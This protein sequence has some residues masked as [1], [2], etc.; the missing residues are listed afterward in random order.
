M[1]QAGSQQGAEEVAALVLADI[2]SWREIMRTSAIAGRLAQCEF[3]PPPW[4]LASARA[5]GGLA[6]AVAC[7]L[8]GLAC[9]SRTELTVDGPNGLDAGS[10]GADAMLADVVEA[11][12]ADT[13][14]A[15]T[16]PTPSLL[17]AQLDTSVDASDTSVDASQDVPMV[18]DT[19]PP[20]GNGDATDPVDATAS[21]DA[22]CGINASVDASLGSSGCRRVATKLIL[23]YPPPMDG[24]APVDAA[25]TI[26]MDCSFNA[27]LIQLTCSAQ[28]ASSTDAGEVDG[29]GDGV[30][31]DSASKT[32]AYSSVAEFV[33]EASLVGNSRNVGFTYTTGELL[34]WIPD[35]PLSRSNVFDSC[36]KIISSGGVAVTEWDPHGRPTAMAPRHICRTDN[37]EHYAYDD[38][39]KTV[40]HMIIT[41]TLTPAPAGV[42]DCIRLVQ[43]FVFDDDGNV[44][45]ATQR[46][47]GTPS[48]IFPRYEVQEST[49]VCI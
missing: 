30:S 28:A 9:A 18:A 11:A 25:P 3:R 4:P 48:G 34:D 33:A 14:E 16:I 24:G 10:Q 6:A 29:G 41:R 5:P 12:P 40:T 44:L 23:V 7:A 8:A 49:L 17:D 39:L 1:G 35:R 15:A 2:A 26:V 43:T 36:G 37:G 19:S 22:A 32:W 13:R 46:Y 20:L 21:M 47:S 42:D 27:K 45:S 31:S 38:T